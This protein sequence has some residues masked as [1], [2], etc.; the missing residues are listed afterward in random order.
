MLT[1]PFYER[2]SAAN[3][4]G[5]WNH[6]AGHLVATKYRVD[7]KVEY[8]A[9]RNG[10]AVLDT[11]PLFKYRIT[12]ADA[13]RLL[14][15]VLARD[16]RA[17]R[18]GHAQY[19]MW[20]DDDGFLIEDG[21]VFRISG[22]EF[23]LT[24]AEPNLAY[25]ERM[26]RGDRVVVEDITDAFGILAVQGPGS[27]TIVSELVPEAAELR[28][29]DLIPAKIGDAPVVVSR[30]GYTGDL[31]YE[32]W[33]EAEDAVAVW[34]ELFAAGAGRGLLPYGSL[35]MHLARI[36]AGLLLIDIDYESSRFAW[37]DGQ[38]ATPIELGY[39]WMFNRLDR[40]DRAF[41][42]RRA[43]ERELGDGSSRFRL[44]GLDVDW[45]SYERAHLD[46]GLPA[47]KDHIPV[48]WAMMVYD[49]TGGVA[50]YASSFA[51][52]PLL[53]RHIAIARVTPT[54]AAAGTRVQIEVTIN[55]R[56]HRVDA[57]VRR[58]PFYDPARK[59]G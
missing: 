36:E 18:P 15:S 26:A 44:V 42:G 4:T 38:R 51:Y 56:N 12:G 23:W 33:V 29:F 37:I 57:T 49:N 52:S 11:S 19:T 48:E 20:C 46:V 9:L 45:R 16:V 7:E 10:A 40:D 14:C 17:C 43:I 5:L 59:T 55:N 35:V 30:T 3:E 58:L 47:A 39:G 13:E 27:R 1:T 2:T 50:G 22:D 28:F 6:W 32:I 54:L 24:S 31:G 21:V 8:F 41:V 53:Q 34:D 25:L